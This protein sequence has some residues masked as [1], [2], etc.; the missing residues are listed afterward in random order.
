MIINYF[1]IQ[2]PDE[3]GFMGSFG[4]FSVQNPPN[5]V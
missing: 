1:I 2:P 5:I 4:G 3:S